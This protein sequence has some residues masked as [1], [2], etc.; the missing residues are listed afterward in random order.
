MRLSCHFGMF[1]PEPSCGM[2]PLT[3]INSRMIPTRPEGGKAVVTLRKKPGC[4]P[5]I[6]RKSPDGHRQGISIRRSL[7][8]SGYFVVDSCWPNVMYQQSMSRSTYLRLLIGYQGETANA[9]SRLGNR[10]DSTFIQCTCMLYYD[11][12]EIDVDAIRAHIA[13]RK[14]M[15]VGNWVP[16]AAR[17][18]PKSRS[19][20]RTT[21][22]SRRAF[23]NISGSVSLPRPS[24]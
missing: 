17:R 7:P 9:H 20:V 19:C 22:P 2:V 15:T 4:F 6:E 13:Q 23:S 3:L 12:L 21:L 5:G 18:S 1:G 24:W 16:L 10:C 11:V 8:Q 14:M